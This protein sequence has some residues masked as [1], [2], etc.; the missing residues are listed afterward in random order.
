MAFVS[1]GTITIASAASTS[2]IMGGF[3]DAEAMGIGAS[4]NAETA[5]LTVG[6]TIAGPF[7]ALQSGGADV[8]L[9]GGKFVTISE[10]AFNAIQL[11]TAS[12]V[13]ADRT[14]TIMKQIK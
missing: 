1:M 3:E 6:A 10:V 4:A 14:F 8:T 11:T 13:A 7:F 9:N 12:G 2:T 5:T